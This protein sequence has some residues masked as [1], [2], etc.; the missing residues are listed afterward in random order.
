MSQ[1]YICNQCQ[2]IIDAQLVLQYLKHIKDVWNELALSSDIP[3]ECFEVEK[4][5]CPNCG[6]MASEIKDVGDNAFVLI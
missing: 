4:F 2:C 6:Y 3:L 1:V 5:Q